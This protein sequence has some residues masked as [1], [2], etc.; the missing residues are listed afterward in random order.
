MPP[1]FETG[2]REDEVYAAGNGIQIP[3]GNGNAHRG[4]VRSERP[5]LMFLVD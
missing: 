1:P 5:V 4:H 3:G 2:D